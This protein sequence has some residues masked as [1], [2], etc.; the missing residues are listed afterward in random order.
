M[1]SN[2]WPAA[3]NTFLNP[4]VGTY[5][6]DTGYELDEVIAQLQ[7]AQAANELILASEAATNFLVDPG[8]SIW[9]DGTTFTSIA[10]GTWGPAGLI[11]R[12]SGAAVHDLLRSTD[13]PAIAAMVPHVNYSAHLDV[14]TADTSIAAGD[15]ALLATR[16]EGYNW[17]PFAQREFT[18]GFWVKAAKTGVHCIFARN[19]GNDRSCVIEYTIAAANTWEYHEATFPASPSTGTW[20]Y[21]NGRGIEIGWTQYA[22]STFQTTA[23]AWQTGNFY[24]T[25]SQVNEV[26]STSNNFKIALLGPPTLGPSGAPFARLPRTLEELR[27]ARYYVRY[28]P[29]A[30]SVIFG[31]GMA[32]TSSACVLLVPVPVPMRAV[33]TLTISSAAHF[34]TATAAFANNDC[35]GATFGLYNGNLMGQP[36]YEV[37]ITSMTGTGLTIG[38]CTFL[39]AQNSAA[40]L[41]FASRIP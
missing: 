6:D 29:A 38:Q 4:G 7:N 14:T 32:Y 34:Y 27:A 30:T 19:S 5:T 8:I 35:A 15:Y 22:G 24:A 39:Y 26:D 3:F 33:P 11:Y 37:Q 17:E 16:I 21:T 36:H 31:F 18:L 13:V 23:G 25:S 20:D 1:P 40:E 41:K 9:P 10:D 2:A 28:A 12:K